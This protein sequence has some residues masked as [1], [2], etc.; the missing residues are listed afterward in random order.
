L[1]W[2]MA[3]WAMRDSN[4]RPMASEASALSIWA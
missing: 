2:M 4:S 3:W 1:C